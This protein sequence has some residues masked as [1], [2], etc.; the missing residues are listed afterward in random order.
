M[1][2]KGNVTDRKAL[3][4]ALSERLGVDADHRTG[5]HSRNRE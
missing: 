1:E 3:V 5:G 2:I 4:K